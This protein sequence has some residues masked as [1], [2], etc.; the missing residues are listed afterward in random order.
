M[1]PHRFE[2]GAFHTKS[3]QLSNVINISDW[4]YTIK[5]ILCLWQYSTGEPSQHL[6]L[7][8]GRQTF[9]SKRLLA[10]ALSVL[11]CCEPLAV[12]SSPKMGQHNE[13]AAIT[14]NESSSLAR[15]ATVVNSRVANKRPVI[16]IIVSNRRRITT[17]S[18]LHNARSVKHGDSD[19]TAHCVL[20]DQNSFQITP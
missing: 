4:K 2:Y 11:R 18:H 9:V 15:L 14:L 13:P 20:F 12:I 1:P 5:T 10:K 19:D 7:T 3:I 17:I 8:A 16:V 6:P